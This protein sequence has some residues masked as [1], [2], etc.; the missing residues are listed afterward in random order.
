[1]SPTSA[2]PGRSPSSREPH[3]DEHDGGA[4]GR[5]ITRR[6][7]RIADVRRPHPEG[8]MTAR[9]MQVTTEDVRAIWHGLRMATTVCH[10]ASRQAGW[11]TDIATGAPRDRNR[12]EML[13]LIHSEI[14][15]ALEG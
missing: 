5:A 15:E 3:N 10:Q 11:Y 12:G 9:I 7:S 8:S 2:W 14:S 6:H 1:M 4:G 13:A